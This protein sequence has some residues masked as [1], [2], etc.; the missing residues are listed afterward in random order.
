MYTY[1]SRRCDIL[2][3]QRISRATRGGPWNVYESIEA[4]HTNDKTNECMNIRLAWTPGA[5]AR[6]AATHTPTDRSC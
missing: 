4:L 5:L 2:A 6:A 1:N 3:Y